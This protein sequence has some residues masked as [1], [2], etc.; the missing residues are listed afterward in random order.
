MRALRDRLTYANTMGTIAVFIA[1][2]GTS[3]AVTQLPRNSVGSSQIRPR[4]IGPSELR[5]QAVSSRAV[6]DRTLGL[7]DLSPA[8]RT[9]LRGAKGDP[10]AQGL[11]GA[12]AAAYHAAINSGGGRV[13]GNAI[14]AS[15][16]GGTGVYALTFARDVSACEAVATLAQVPGGSTVDPPPGRVTVRPS[17]TGI[18]VHTFDAAG[19]VAD[20]PFNVIVVC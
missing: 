6:R 7:R 3:Y 10:G 20:L 5:S 17:G 15:H 9:A 4:A 11:P 12:S 13:R 2:G 19:A 16:D 18:A 14:T 8:A 1:L